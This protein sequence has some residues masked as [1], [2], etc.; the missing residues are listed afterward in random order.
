MKI[1]YAITTHNEGASIGNLISLL[2][3]FKRT[4]DEIIILDDYSTDTLTKKLLLK[5][6]NVFKRRFNNNFSEHKNYL[7]SL[8]SG[9]YIFQFDGDEIPSLNLLKFIQKV[10]YMKP[11]IDLFWIPRDNKLFNIDLNYIKKIKWKI[12]KTGRINYPDYQGR[13]YKNTSNIKW[14]RDVHEVIEG[15]KTQMILPKDFKLDII[16]HRSMEHQLRS[17]KFYSENFK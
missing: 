1:S 13:V 12:D 16:H 2:Q 5:N 11:N 8:C 15:H 17:N 10:I 14:T 6:K 7:N 4:H 9:D 3:S